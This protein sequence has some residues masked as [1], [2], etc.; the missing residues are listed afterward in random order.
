[1]RKSHNEKLQDRVFSMNEYNQ[2]SKIFETK[3]YEVTQLD[4]FFFVHFENFCFP[5]FG[6]EIHIEINFLV[7]G[8]KSQRF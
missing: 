5:D 1:M 7:H 6:T 8:I 4:Q 3:I 2:Y